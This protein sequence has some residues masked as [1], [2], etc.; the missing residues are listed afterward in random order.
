MRLHSRRERVGFWTVT[1]LVCCLSPLGALWLELSQAHHAFRQQSSLI[2]EALSQRLANL[3]VILVSLV[4]LHHASDV[5]STAQFSA[6]TQELLDSYPYIGSVLLLTHTSQNQRQAVVQAMRESGFPQFDITERGANGKL[7]SAA[8][9]PSYMPIRAIEPFG[10]LS[11]TL[12]GY[13]ATSEPLLASTINRAITTGTV[14]AS[15]PIRFRQPTPSLLIFKAVYQGR[16]TPADANR[17]Q[18]LLLG[19]M[20]LE[21]PSAFITDLV[22]NHPEFEISMRHRVPQS[23]GTEPFYYRE[24]LADV[25]TSIFWWPKW[26]IS[27]A[28]DLFGQ[29]FELTITYQVNTKIIKGWHLGLALLLPLVSLLI[30]RLALQHRRAAQLAAHRAHLAKLAEE[31]RFKDFAETAADWFWELNAALQFTYVSGR[32]R[33]S[34]GMRSADLLRQRWADVFLGQVDNPANVSQHMSLLE[35]HAPFQHV[36]YEWKRRDGSTSILRFSGRPMMDTAGNF[37]GYRGTA[38]DITEQMQSEAARQEAETQYRILVDYASD[39]IVVLQQRKIVYRN[40]ALLDVLHTTLAD[41]TDRHFIDF[42]APEDHDR[43]TVYYE[44]RLR[45]E[46]MPAQYEVTLVTQDQKRIVMEARPC[47]LHY[48][49]QPAT[50]VIMR[51]VTE[52]KQAQ[53]ELRRAKETAEMANQA[54]SEFLANISHELRTP[55]HGILSFASLGFKRVATV[56]PD[57]LELYFDKIRHSGEG[58]LA[59]LNDLLDL[60]KL[61]SGHMAFDFQD[62]DICPMLNAVIGEFEPMFSE[63]SLTLQYEPPPAP[64]IACVAPPR[65]MQVWRNLFS[66]AVKFAP[67]GSTII[68]HLFQETDTIVMTVQD[69]GVGIPPDELDSIFDK[70]VQ[71]SKTR[72]GAG[73]TGLGLPICREIMTAHRGQIWADNSPQGGAVFRVELPQLPA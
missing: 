51:N 67:S 42:V 39:A 48:Q 32:A 43:M 27:H 35:A 17:R 33:D 3:D 29:P 62:C 49:G 46:D 36:I 26:T 30:I 45:G 4:G 63:R 54:K 73:G 71:S 34:L 6:F 64:L 38:T 55:L 52:R 28:L 44:G 1:I 19:V 18:A 72:T 20:A 12:F 16:Y 11:A 60:A 53:E 2:H 40:Q 50:L 57:R 41:T 8:L 59:L 65:M 61:E 9:R 15:V 7:Q 66:N 13:D 31:Q 22:T 56:S 5:L 58:L 10:P 37:T 23:H 47:I 21:L 24:R 70:F 25:Q 68:C 69:E 14:A